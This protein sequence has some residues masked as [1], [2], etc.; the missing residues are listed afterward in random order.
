[1]HRAPLFA[2][3]VGVLSVAAGTGR[4]DP[5]SLPSTMP[6]SSP[7]APAQEAIPRATLAEMY[8]SELGDLYHAED[9]EQ[10]YAAHEL[11]EKFFAAT[12][13]RDRKSAIAAIQQTRLDP[14]LI[15]RLS[16]LRMYWPQLQ[17]GVYHIRE[18]AG[19]WTVDYF[20]GLPP[21]YD[22]TKAWPLVIKLASASPFQ[23]QPPPELNR[24]VQMYT[25]WIKDELARHADAVVL[26]PLLD[27]DEMYGP[28]YA[29]MNSVIQPM[30]HAADRVNIDPA[31]V[32]LM[33]HSD[34]AQAVWNLALHY[35]TYFAAFDALAGAA[36]YDWQRVR[37]INLCNLLPVV[38]HDTDD[39][40]IKVDESR[41]LVRAL[42]GLKLDVEYL[43]TKNLG[44]A[45]PEPIV[46]ETYQKMRARTRK[47]YPG[48]VSIQSSR[49]DPMFNRSDWVQ[50]WQPLDEGS[51]RR[52]YLHRASSYMRIFSNLMRIDATCK[53]NRIEATTNNVDSLSFYLND[54][55]VD[56]AKPVTVVVNRKVR[57]EG[58]VKPD[59]E[60]MLNDEMFLGRGWRYFA[61]MVDIDVIPP[62]TRPAPA[63]GPATHS[64]T[65]RIGPLPDEP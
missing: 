10:L 29:G 62:A 52:L 13:T 46:E 25:A 26:M 49:P 8:R 34:A 38:W 17:A 16:R 63:T 12:S 7:S 20:L 5:L 15:G 65:I 18:H 43:E 39:S 36:R 61:G 24:V 4:G 23:T 32:Y 27:M 21:T 11:I 14:N 30:L 45:P 2:L 6:G 54:Q 55:M 1:M 40:V 60:K 35:P 64:G 28:T 48:E 22:R 37:L 50:L 19:P 57:F 53:D 3:M 42:R 47:L 51:E 31:R 59:I 33:G 58:I 41:S 56:F 44:H 9:D